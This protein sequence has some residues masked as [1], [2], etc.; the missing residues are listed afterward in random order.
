MVKRGK[1]GKVGDRGVPM[2][3]VGYADDHSH[4]CMRMFNPATGK[5]S[6]TRDVIRMHR[7]YYQDEIQGETAFLPEIRV[8]IPDINPE[9]LEAGTREPGGVDHVNDE[10]DVENELAS[11]AE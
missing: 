4:D 11:L 3:F 10:D 6:E 2:M 8:V 9:P 5:I 7:M 1:N